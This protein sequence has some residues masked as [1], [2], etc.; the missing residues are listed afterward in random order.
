MAAGDRNKLGKPIDIVRHF[1]V[2]DKT[3]CGRTNWSYAT[4]DINDVTCI[5]C[6][7]ALIKRNKLL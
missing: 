5:A 3:I 1:K 2:D 6:K 4:T 7:K